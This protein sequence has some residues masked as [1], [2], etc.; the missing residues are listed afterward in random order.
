MGIKEELIELEQKVLKKT[1]SQKNNAI[2][3]H[4]KAHMFHNKNIH[5]EALIELSKHNIE[6]FILD[7]LDKE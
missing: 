2:L 4:A 1:E 7:N 5:K 3:L 6:H